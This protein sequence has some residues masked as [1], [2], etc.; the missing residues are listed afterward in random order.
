[1]VRC[2]AAHDDL[3]RCLALKI[4]DR[5]C[6]NQNWCGDRQLFRCSTKRCWNTD[7]A[8]DLALL[9]SFSIQIGQ[10]QVERNLKRLYDVDAVI[11]WG[12]LVS[13]C[14]YINAGCQ[15]LFIVKFMQKEGLKQTRLAILTQDA[16]QKPPSS[17]QQ[18]LLDFW[19]EVLD[20]L[21]GRQH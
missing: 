2:P 20:H 6:E 10:W 11:S 16:Q 18:I 4:A 5:I 21:Q 19:G 3:E 15:A 17:E 1:M 9:S 7:W 12:F 14:K 8:N 13:R